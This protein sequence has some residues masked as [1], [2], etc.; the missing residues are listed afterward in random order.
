[1]VCRLF[2]LVDQDPKL[3]RPGEATTAMIGDAGKLTA[4][5]AWRP[6]IP[7]EQTLTDLLPPGVSG[8]AGPAGPGD[9]RRRRRGLRRVA[10][11]SGVE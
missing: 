1:M 3:S 9:P 10:A 4:L 8:A 2:D 6:E 5:T 11:G 7:I